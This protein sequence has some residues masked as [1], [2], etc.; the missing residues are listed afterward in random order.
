VLSRWPRSSAATRSAD[1]ILRTVGRATSLLILQAGPVLAEDGPQKGSPEHV[2]AKAV[3]RRYWADFGFQEAAG[4]YLALG[5][6]VDAL[7]A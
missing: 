6:M 3:L 2:A 4:D 7:D 5:E 1:A